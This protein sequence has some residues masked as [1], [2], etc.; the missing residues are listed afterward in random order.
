MFATM[1]EENVKNILSQIS[2][3]NK[4][5]EQITLVGAT[6]MQTTESINLAIKSGLKV[7]GENK[8]DEFCDKYDLLLPCEKHFIGYLQT[9]KIKYL[10]GKVDLYHSVGR[11]NLA[12]E[13]DKRSQLKELTSNI[14]LEINIGREESKSGF[15]IED[16][17]QNYE[18]IMNM[19]NLKVKGLM[20]MLP[21]STD[22]NYLFDLASNMRQIFDKYKKT[23]KDMCYL[24]MGMSGDYEVCIEAGSNMIRVGSGIFGKRE[25]QI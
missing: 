25:Y 19:S 17:E 24:S 8:A 3:G 10:L 13:L 16:F 20:T 23:N 12:Q 6:K 1:I 15:L 14:L 7:V 21:P 9:N 11:L 18:L 22:K 4:Y 2:K 5:G